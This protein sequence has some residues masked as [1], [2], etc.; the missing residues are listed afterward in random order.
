M[1]QRLSGAELLG[2]TV[3][4]ARIYAAETGHPIAVWAYDRTYMVRTTDDPPTRD[5][6]FGAT[7]ERLGYVW[8]NGTISEVG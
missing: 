4:V 2:R 5:E 6:N 8:P 7:W 1:E 3:S